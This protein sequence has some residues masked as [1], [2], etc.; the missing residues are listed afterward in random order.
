[1]VINGISLKLLMPNH[2]LAK[3]RQEIQKIFVDPSW[4]L[5]DPGVRIFIYGWTSKLLAKSSN[6]RWYFYLNQIVRKIKE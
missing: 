2:H 3:V 4:P 1:M 5:V 6:T